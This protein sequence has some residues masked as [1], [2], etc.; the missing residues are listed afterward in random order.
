MLRGYHDTRFSFDP[1]RKVLWRS[2]WKYHFSKYVQ[3]KDCVLELGSG[4]GDFIN[5]V[6]ARRRVAVDS[7][8]D[9]V[10]HLAPGVEGHVGNAV[11]LSFLD[12]RSVNL[13]FASNLV[14]HLS[15]DDFVRMLREL[16]RKL[17][18]GGRL[19]L[20]QPNFRYAFRE[21]FDD[22]THVAVYT[23]LG[24]CDLLRAE[25]FEILECYPKFLPLTIKSRFKVWPFLIWVYLNSPLKP[26]GKQMLVV[27]RAAGNTHEKTC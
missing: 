3:P 1:R 23:H 2:L 5:S 9:F 25:G 27:A 10:R 17:A 6:E 13:A 7:W 18:I 14:E 12:D 15:Q 4:Y 16:Q 20:L 19:A 24:L 11:E 8:P 22:Y 21:Y 26:F